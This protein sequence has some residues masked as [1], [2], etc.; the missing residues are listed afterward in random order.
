LTV[1]ARFE[2]G[3]TSRLRSSDL[4]RTRREDH[5]GD[6]R[7]RVVT[8]VIPGERRLSTYSASA[9]LPRAMAAQ[10][11]A[12][13]RRTRNRAG[14]KGGSGLCECVLGVSRPIQQLSLK[15][16]GTRGTLEQ[17]SRA[18]LLVELRLDL[19]LAEPQTVRRQLVRAESRRH[20]RPQHVS[21]DK[22]SRFAS[23]GAVSRRADH[24][25]AVPIAPGRKAG[26][27]AM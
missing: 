13:N 5:R 1:R 24:A 17:T 6:R 16:R 11:S 12:A 3:L 7:R 4:V 14:G 8:R 9:D 23:S 20:A 2:P 26:R 22:P 10:G 15:K 18:P 27:P 25:G 19:R 21:G